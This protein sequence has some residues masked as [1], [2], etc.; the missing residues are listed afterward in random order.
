MVFSELNTPKRT[1]MTPGPVE[2]DPRVLRAMSTPILGQFDPAF[3][4]IMNEVME[5]IRHVYQ[6]NNYCSFPIDGTS[7]AGIEAVLCSIIEPRDRVL[8][9][10]YGRFGH[11]LVEVCERYGA[12]VHTIEAKWGEVFDPEEV[13]EAIKQVSPQIVAIVH[14]ETSTGQMQP[15]KEIGNTCREMDILLVVDAV[16]SIGG[17]D[18]KT[19]EWNIDAIIGGTQKCLSVPSGLA[20]ISYNHRI[21]SKIQSRKKVERGI[22]TE[23]DKKIVRAKPAIASNYF[24]LSMIQDYWGPRR[25]NHHTEATSMIYALREGLR[26][27]LEEGLEARFHRHKLHEAALVAGIQAMGLT[28]FGNVNHKLPTVTCVEI[29]PGVNGESVRRMLLEEFGIEIASSFGPLQGKIWRIG[30]MGYSCRKE[31]ILFLLGALE[32]VLIR[33]GILVNRGEALQAAL[34]LYVAEEKRTIKIG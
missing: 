11:L 17:V 18:I 6:T 25:L 20:P 33:H 30:T 23:D 5:M 14:G 15:L 2:V 26:I 1:I 32:A 10:I 7:R 13:I 22:E 34:D 21:E 9:P 29:P 12:T 19:D 16:A 31:N 28:L 3:T 24:D 4:K 8:V 27:I